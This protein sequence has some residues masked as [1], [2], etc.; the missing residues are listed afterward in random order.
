V[1]DSLA[2]SFGHTAPGVRLEVSCDPIS[3][4]ADDAIAIALLSNEVVTNS[5]K[6]AFANQSSGQI[7]VRLRCSAEQAMVL[8]ISDTGSGGKL[9]ESEHGMGMK[10]MRLLSAQVRGALDIASPAAEGGTKVTLKLAR[11]ADCRRMPAPVEAA[12]A[13]GTAA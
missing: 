10:L 13:S 5:Y 7:T 9:T 8:R 1:C 6:H 2:R 3:L 4:P 12:S 11:A